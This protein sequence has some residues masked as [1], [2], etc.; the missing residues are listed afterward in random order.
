M[1]ANSDYKDEEFTTFMESTQL[2]DLHEDLHP[3]QT[4]PTYN[5]GTRKIDY[6]LGTMKISSSVTKGGLTTYNDGLKFSDHRALFIDI[7]ETDVF[8]DKGSDPTARENRGLRTKSKEQ[9][10]AYLEI[11]HSHFAEHNI[12]EKCMKLRESAP[13]IEVKLIKQEAD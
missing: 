2:L 12:Y 7:K 1:D 3:I 9:T 4:P 11:V 5:R 10:K 8:V 13:T 6:I